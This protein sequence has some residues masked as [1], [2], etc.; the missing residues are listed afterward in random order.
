ML[1][2]QYSPVILAVLI[3][4]SGSRG[5]LAGS[6]QLS[7]CH[8]ADSFATRNLAKARFA[9]S[10]PNM[11]PQFEGSGLSTIDQAEVRPVQA[12]SLCRL[13][14]RTINRDENLP[15]STARSIYLLSMG[16]LFWVADRAARAGEFSAV[17][18]LNSSLTQ[19]RVRLMQ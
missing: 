1:A 5:S 13:A 12:D 14:I 18:L 15:D 19:V 2:I 8:A 3:G 10:L 4:V 16:R 17:W 6:Q 7:P 11:A 9:L